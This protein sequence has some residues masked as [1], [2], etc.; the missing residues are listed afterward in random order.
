MTQTLTQLVASVQ[1]MLIDD[2][3]RFTTATCTAAIREALKTWNCYMPVNAATRI[4]TVADQKDYE[5]SDEVDASTALD[6]TD[7][8]EYDTDGDDHEPIPFHQ[9]TE[10]E[11]I[12]FRI[13]T[14]VTPGAGGEILARYTQ[15]HT[16]SGLDSAAESTLSAFYDTILVKGAAGEACAIRSRARTE[17]INLQDSVTINYGALAKELKTE[18]MADLMKLAKKNNMP[19]SAPDTSAW[20]DKY[21]GW[22]Q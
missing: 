16:I 14:P 1:A 20:D 18:Y 4:D 21:H 19:T 17:T 13:K 5:L 3:T 2:G 15:P 12:W 10:D 11:R 7:I 22:D 9:W 6:I 8:L